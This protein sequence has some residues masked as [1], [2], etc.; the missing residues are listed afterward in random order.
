MY[1]DVLYGFWPLALAVGWVLFALSFVLPEPAA[2]TVMRVLAVAAFV[3][4]AVFAIPGI[5]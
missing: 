1:W 4:A 5:A 3:L 2:V